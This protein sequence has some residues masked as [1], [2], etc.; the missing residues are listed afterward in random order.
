MPYPSTIYTVSPSPKGGYDLTAETWEIDRRGEKDCRIDLLKHFE[1][2][3]DAKAACDRLD[4]ATPR[5]ISWAS[6]TNLY[7]ADNYLLP[8]AA[9]CEDEGLHVRAIV[10]REAAER[11]KA[12]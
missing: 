4:G 2:W 5:P 1:T 9:K 8:H 11:L 6:M 3:D 12:L 10:L 7:L